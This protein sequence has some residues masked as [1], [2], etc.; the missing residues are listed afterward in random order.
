MDNTSAHLSATSPSNFSNVSRIFASESALKSLDL[1][2][3]KVTVEGVRNLQR[4]P[5]LR[6]LLLDRCDVGDE[7]LSFARAEM[8]FSLVTTFRQNV[9]ESRHSSTFW[10]TWLWVNSARVL[11]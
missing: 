7:M 2:R 1:A 6:D 10:R 4:M 5:E 3:T 8:R 11:N 9:G